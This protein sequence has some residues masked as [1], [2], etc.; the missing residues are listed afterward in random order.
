MI[1]GAE[2]EH[3]H[4]FLNTVYGSK[5]G[6]GSAS[7]YCSRSDLSGRTAKYRTFTVDYGLLSEVRSKSKDCTNPYVETGSFSCHSLR[8]GLKSV[9]GTTG[10]GQRKDYLQLLLFWYPLE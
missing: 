8:F 10:K 1:V 7:K 5:C 3:R 2:K 6:E 9:P 4:N